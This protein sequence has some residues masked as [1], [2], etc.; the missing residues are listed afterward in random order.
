MLTSR[1]LYAKE[2]T[3]DE[4]SSIK[5]TIYHKLH[6]SNRNTFQFHSSGKLFLMSPLDCC[7][8]RWELCNSLLYPNQEWEGG[9]DTATRPSTCLTHS[10][11]SVTP[12]LPSVKSIKNLRSIRKFK[13]ARHL[14]ID[15][16][17]CTFYIQIF[18]TVSNS[19]NNSELVR[20]LHS[21]ALLSNLQWKQ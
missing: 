6:N 3:F 17:L 19:F 2:F 4:S 16:G 21:V 18:K 9:G 1:R 15:R 7:F 8:R 20:T 5:Q 10:V 11:S 13:Y 14:Y 12:P